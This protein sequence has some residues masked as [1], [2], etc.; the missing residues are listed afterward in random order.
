MDDRQYFVGLDVGKVR[1]FA[2]LAVLDRA[3]GIDR[4]RSACR[5]LQRWRLGTPYPVVAESVVS[6]LQRPPLPGCTLAVDAT[7]VGKAV[8]DLLVEAIRDKAVCTL[9][10]VTITAGSAANLG[11]DGTVRVPK[12]DLVGVLKE[13][14]GT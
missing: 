11:P 7:G 14:L 2:A 6:L 4:P 12:K 5:H 3:S 8:V 13:L 1:D 10:P 9:L